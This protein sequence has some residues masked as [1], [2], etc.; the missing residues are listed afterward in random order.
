[1]PAL[2]VYSLARQDFTEYCFRKISLQM[3]QINKVLVLKE[4]TLQYPEHSNIRKK[5][6]I[7][8]QCAGEHSHTC[9]LHISVWPKDQSK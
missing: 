5:M 1:M 6:N 9:S 8:H 3:F 7:L 4:E 2:Y